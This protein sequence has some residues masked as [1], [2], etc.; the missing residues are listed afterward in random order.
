MLKRALS[1]LIFA[2]LSVVLAGC[3]LF[4]GAGTQ[5]RADFAPTQ[6]GFEVD[7]DGGIEIF[8]NSVTF[9]N[10][11]DAAAALIT[12]YEIQIYNDAGSELL[13]I[14]TDLFNYH[15][16]IP[17]PAGYTCPEDDSQN[18]VV[19]TRI[20]QQ[21]TSEPKSFVFLDG[22]TALFILGSGLTRARAE[23]TFYADQGG[24]PIHWTE[25]V[26]VTYPVGGE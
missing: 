25:S 11:A 10:P 12:G 15:L 4:G 24:R 6:I 1:P 8:S 3:G 13:G 20:P 2:F 19:G 16:A 26:T 9:V 18:C 17:V 5:L 14:G 23:I 7:D 21:T 22:Q